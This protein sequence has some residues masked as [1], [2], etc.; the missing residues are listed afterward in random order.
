MGRVRRVQA[1]SNGQRERALAAEVRRDAPD[2]A[3]LVWLI[4]RAER[5]VY[6]ALSQA[7]RPHAVTPSEY[8][9]L[10]QLGEM[11]HASSA[12][13]ARAAFVSPQ[14]MLGLVRSLEGKGYL[15]RDRVSGARTIETSLTPAGQVVLDDAA[16]S[17]TNVEDAFAGAVGAAQLETV[18]DALARTIALI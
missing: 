10:L 11:G 1:G 16:Q 13:L 17:I 14:A 18:K 4:K 7:L 3:E 5:A 9:A 12:E 15:T 8:G 6:Q 2:V